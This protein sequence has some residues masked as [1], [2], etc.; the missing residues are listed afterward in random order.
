MYLVIAGFWNRGIIYSGLI[1]GVTIPLLG[2]L[3]ASLHHDK[4]LEQVAALEKTPYTAY[5]A[6]V[7]SLPEKR[8]ST[9]RVEAEVTKI[10]T[11]T[12]WVPAPARAYLSLPQEAALLPK[13]G[14]ALLVQQQLKRPPEPLNPAEFDYRRFLRFKGVA[15][16]DY[17]APEKYRVVPFPARGPRYWSSRVSDWADRSL[18]QSLQH[19]DAYGLLKAM[20]LGRR[21][22]LR[23][24]LIGS[25]STSGAVHVLS[26]SGLHVGIFFLLLSLGLG[27][28][29]KYPL[30][31]YLYLVILT[32]LLL[33]YALLTGLSPSVLR[34][35]CMCL[36][37]VVAE[38]FNRRAEPVN[39]LAFSAFLI[40]L[41]DPFALYAVGF[42]LSYLAV[43]GILLFY[44]PIERLISTEHFLLRYLWRA[45]AVSVSAQL[46]TFPV[47][48]YYFHQFPVYFWLVN[49][50]VVAL[51]FVLMPGALALVIVSLLPFKALF[52]VVHVVV[53]MAALATNWLVTFPSRLPGYSAQGLYLDRVEVVLLLVLILGAY[54]TY[55]RR[56][57]TTLKYLAGVALVFFLYA[58]THSLRTYHRQQLVVHAVPRHSVLSIKDQSTLYLLADEAFRQD[59]N[60][61]RFRLENYQIQQL[62]QDTVFL[63]PG[64]QGTSS[65]VVVRQVSGGTL[66]AWPGGTLYAGEGVPSAAAV[67]YVLLTSRTYPR[68]NPFSVQS[69]QPNEWS[70]PSR[71]LY[72]LGGQMGVRTRERWKEI[73]AQQGYRYYDPTTE[74]A[75]VLR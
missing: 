6:V 70:E 75:L 68:E 64:G 61:Y 26:V 73:L 3:A 21:D 15:W 60:A 63:A 10:R 59:T 12:G 66:V 58:T 54:Y 14:E 47:S 57:W 46:L 18:R 28:L 43:L 2:Y 72:I 24:D 39:T 65:R 16:T 1:L 45:T 22:D 40:L 13:P 67:D 36:V 20:L 69:S 9:F 51:A 5:L 25:Y 19:D 8:Q 56:E 7:K 4:Y 50:L 31:K 34:A 48:V 74:G 17:L 32:A 55:R 49:P 27:W 33:F 38:V 11:E 44:R 23:N 41:F 35:T 52:T 30:G 71:T 29:K 37:W 42:Q 62:I 53:Y